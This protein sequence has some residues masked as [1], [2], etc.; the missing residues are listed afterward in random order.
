MTGFAVFDFYF[1]HQSADV[2]AFPADVEFSEIS[3]EVEVYFGLSTDWT[4]LE[5]GFLQT[6]PALAFPACARTLILAAM[7]LAAS[8]KAFDAGEDGFART[9]GFPS[10]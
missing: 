9:M 4:D 8:V 7:F 3:T 6:A 1:H 10:S 5:V 2:S